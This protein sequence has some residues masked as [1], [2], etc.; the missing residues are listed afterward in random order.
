MLPDK[1]EWA[2]EFIGSDRYNKIIDLIG[3]LPDPKWL[4]VWNPRDGWRYQE[5]RHFWYMHKVLPLQSFYILDFINKKTNNAPIVNICDGTNLFEGMFNVVLWSK[6]MEDRRMGV[7]QLY[8]LNKKFDNVYHSSNHRT[9]TFEEMNSYLY[10]YSAL[11]KDYGY[12][13]FDSFEM[14][15]RTNRDF[16]NEHELFKYYK[17]MSF[18]DQ[19]VERLSTRVDI[20]HYENLIELEPQYPDN[21]YDEVDGDIRI[22][23]KSKLSTKT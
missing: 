10:R 1:D 22:L 11:P 21:S 5:R 20:V 3:C 6:S 4:H 17:L 9:L 23:F 18:I 14:L 12:I 2:A 19:A 16:I 8:D 15:R 13:A 7:Y